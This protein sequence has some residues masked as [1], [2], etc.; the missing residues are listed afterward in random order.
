MESRSLWTAVAFVVVALLAPAA[1]ASAQTVN[2]PPTA[3]ITQ[4]PGTPVTLEKVAFNSICSS[5][6]EGRLTSRAWDIDNDGQFDDGTGQFAWRT[7]ST[8]GTYT[9]RLRVVDDRNQS[10]I[11]TWSV[12]VKNR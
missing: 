3:C 6:P 10:D 4:S 2:K 7:W 11:E 8:A 1:S 9:V 5:D 12:V